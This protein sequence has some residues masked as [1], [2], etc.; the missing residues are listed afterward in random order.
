MARGETLAAGLT[1]PRFAIEE[2]L[3]VCSQVIAG[4]QYIHG[5]GLAH[6]DLHP[7]NVILVADCVKIID[8]TAPKQTQ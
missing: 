7:G 8:T 5:K 2:V 3:S 1:G 4:L 6:G